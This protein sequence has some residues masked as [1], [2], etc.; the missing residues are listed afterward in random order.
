MLDWAMEY[1]GLTP[2]HF[3]AM[4]TGTLICLGLTQRIKKAIQMSDSLTASIAFIV[5]G[6]ATYT[7]SPPMGIEFAWPA[8][9]LSIVV[10]LWT[11][12]GFKVFKVIAK[13]RNWT[14]VEQL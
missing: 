6:F 4:F 11:P 9:W 7:L 3:L 10:G 2:T 12:A 14:W 1:L 13:K 5:G 8:L